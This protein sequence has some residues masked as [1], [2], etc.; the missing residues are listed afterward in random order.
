MGITVIVDCNE[1][2]V[3]GTA[4]AE[5]VVTVLLGPPALPRHPHAPTTGGTE[6]F[7]FDQEEQD[8][9]AVLA[10]AGMVPVLRLVS[11]RNSSAARGVS[12]DGVESDPRRIG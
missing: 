2:A 1:C 6:R 11:V 7:R 5:C 12:P 10:E 8:A 9:I 4:C 3:R